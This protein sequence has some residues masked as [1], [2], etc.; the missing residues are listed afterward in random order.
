MGL[1]GMFRCVC[2]Q[3]GI[4]ELDSEGDENRSVV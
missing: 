2:D 3:V 4:L 1:K